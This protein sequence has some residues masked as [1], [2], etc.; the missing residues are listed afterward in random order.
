[1][2]RPL[3]NQLVPY[4]EHLEGRRWSE[5][6]DLIESILKKHGCRTVVDL[7]CGPGLHAIRL[8]KKGYDVT[9]VDIS[10]ENIRFARAK[11]KRMKTSPHFVVGSYY[12]YHPGR[13]FDAAL[14][15]N[16]SVP[17]K[18]TEL[19]RFLKNTSALLREGGLLIFDYERKSDLVQGD[20]GRPM[21]DTWDLSDRIIVRSSVG[22]MTS[23]V[24]SSCDVYIV[25]P[26]KH[27][28]KA[29]NEVRRYSGVKE[30]EE[31]Q[32]YVDRSYVRFFSDAEIRRFARTSGFKVLASSTL[33]RGRY[34]RVYSTLKRTSRRRRRTIRNLTLRSDA[35]SK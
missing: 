19:E 15:L 35:V 7:G 28:E 29:P 34:K 17:V 26:K 10:R 31:V 2:N 21:I 13:D 9:G 32:V 12:E 3:Y 5:E 20:L 22:Q 27:S 1:M 18:D 11:G 8:A 25:Y 16:W 14:C 30:G 6:L 23:S 4:Y 33:P 24:M